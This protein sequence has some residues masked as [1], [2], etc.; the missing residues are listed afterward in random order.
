MSAVIFFIGSI[1]WGAIAAQLLVQVISSFVTAAIFLY[2]LAFSSVRRKLNAI[3]F[4]SALTQTVFFAGLFAGGFVLIGLFAH[5]DS[6]WNANYTAGFVG[7]VIT[8]IYCFIQ[9]PDKILLARLCA[10]MPRFAERARLLAPNRRLT[11]D[12]A[13]RIA[14]DISGKPN[15]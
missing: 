5:P 12:E 9:V 3:F 10:M 1:I 14:T 8:F 6:R 2:G 4:A 7:F 15:H 13:M 11:R